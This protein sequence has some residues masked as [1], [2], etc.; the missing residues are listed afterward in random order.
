MEKL[1]S[2]ETML[3]PKKTRYECDASSIMTDCRNALFK[4]GRWSISG[5]QKVLRSFKNEQKAKAIA[6]LVTTYASEML[7]LNQANKSSEKKYVQPAVRNTVW[8]ILRQQLHCREKILLE[9]ERKFKLHVESEYDEADVAGLTDHC[10]KI[11][12]SD[13]RL[14]TWEDKA[15]CKLWSAQDV[16]QVQAEMMIECQEL[17]EFFSIVPTEYCGVLQNGCN[18]TF[19]F[20]TVVRGKFLWSYVRTPATFENGFVSST[21][22]AVVAQFLEHMLVIVDSLYDE[23]VMPK[24]IIQSMSLSSILEGREDDGEGKDNYNPSDPAGRAGQKPDAPG[25]GVGA[26]SSSSTTTKNTSKKSGSRTKRCSFEDF[27]NKENL[28]LPL[29]TCNV[30]KLPVQ[31]VRVLY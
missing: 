2:I 29:T 5:R 25:R 26:R 13:A 21:A 14:A 12:D 28:I 9:N 24:M 1:F 22:C 15:I 7:A 23:V 17:E 16:A 19:L 6:D 4:C 27:A 18:W 8:P 3:C 11:V 30:N 20:R 10:L 31:S